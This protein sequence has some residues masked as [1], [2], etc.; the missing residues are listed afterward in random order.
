M[1]WDKVKLWFRCKL[2]AITRDDY[3]CKQISI[4]LLKLTQE[5]K[6]DW[7]QMGFYYR[8]CGGYLD[9]DIERGFCGRDRCLVARG[10]SYRKVYRWVDET[11][12][13][14]KEI[15]KRERGGDQ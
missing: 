7:V 15:K 11:K 2:P 1:L 5:G 8:A 13:L 14:Y 10:R 12:E 4:R 6:I 3:I 9:Y